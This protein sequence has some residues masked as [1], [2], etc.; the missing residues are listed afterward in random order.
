M[1]NILEIQSL[2]KSFKD[3]SLKDVSFKLPY[4]YIMGL[5]GPNG[6]GKTTIIKLIMNLLLKDSGDITVFDRDHQKHEA[7][8]KSRI[9]FVYDQPP[10]P[11]TLKLDKIRK[12]IAPFYD[13]WD[14]AKFLEL[15]ERFELPLKRKFQK[16][17]QGMKMK[18]ALVIA[19][20]HNADL[21]I[22]DEPTSGIDPVFRRELLGILLELI[23]NEQKSILFSTHITSDL[24]R[25]ADYITYI[26][27]GEIAISTTKQELIENWGIVKTS[28]SRLSDFRGGIYLGHRKNEFGCEILTSDKK[29][30][31][32]NL[33]GEE[34]IASATLEDIMFLMHEGKAGA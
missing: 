5:I 12:I 4:G 24:D 9:G 25:V 13:A 1:E 31:G 34:T 21:I 23:Q 10:F 7:Y 29:A 19:L 15:M 3:F 11:P 32:Q 16:L 27:K 28:E 30:A 18:F 8:V 17:S 22:M 26:R 33:T 2:N 14:E 6:A 20:S